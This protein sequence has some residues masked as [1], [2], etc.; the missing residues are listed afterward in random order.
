MNN[1]VTINNAIDDKLCNEIINLGNSKKHKNGVTGKRKKPT[2]LRDC[3]VGWIRHKELPGKD[4]INGLVLRANKEMGWSFNLTEYLYRTAQFT[5]YDKNNYY[6]WH[7]DTSGNIFKNRAISISILLS[8]K[9]DFDGGEFQFEDGVVEE[10]SRKGDMVI[11]P[12]KLR[13]RVT[14]IE[15]GKRYSLVIWFEKGE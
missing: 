15:K 10:L 4:I 13:H 9:K 7:R 8:D 1:Y 2:S 12:S 11:F 6:N 14:P 3:M 5:V